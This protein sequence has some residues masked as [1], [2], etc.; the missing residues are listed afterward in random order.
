MDESA[1]A[2]AL[3]DAYLTRN[4]RDYCSFVPAYKQ[5]RWCADEGRYIVC[6]VGAHFRRRPE[7]VIRALRCTC[8]YEKLCAPTLMEPPPRVA[9]EQY[10]MDGER[11]PRKYRVWIFL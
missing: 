2:V 8:K 10:G 5:L 4:V 3:V 7:C 9:R 11:V 6:H 1:Y